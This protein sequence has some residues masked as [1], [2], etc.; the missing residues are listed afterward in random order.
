MHKGYDLIF[1]TGREN[2]ALARATASSSLQ[3]CLTPFMPARRRQGIRY[4]RAPLALRY[5]TAETSLNISL[6]FGQDADSWPGL[7][8]CERGRVLNQGLHGKT[9][10]CHSQS[11]MR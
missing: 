8:R 3:A 6:C 7:R 1:M 10:A 2:T 11:Q 4:A 9:F 5:V